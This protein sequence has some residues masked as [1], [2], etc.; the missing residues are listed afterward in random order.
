[1]VGHG[2]QRTTTDYSIYFKQFFG[3]KFIILLYVDD[4]LIVGQDK[5]K[6]VSLRKS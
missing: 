3:E 4:M 1:M 5:D 2:Y 6:S